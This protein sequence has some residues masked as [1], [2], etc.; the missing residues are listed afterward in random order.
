MLAVQQNTR[1]GVR[2]GLLLILTISSMMVFSGGWYMKSQP[3]TVSKLIDSSLDTTTSKDILKSNLLPSAFLPNKRGLFDEQGLENPLLRDA[4]TALSLRSRNAFVPLP[5]PTVLPKDKSRDFAR[6]KHRFTAFPEYDLEEKLVEVASGDTLITLLQR[7]ANI[8]GIEATIA[9][10]ALSKI[11]RGR[12]QPGQQFNLVMA[13]P[14]P[15]AIIQKKKLA[16]MFFRLNAESDVLLY[17]TS[18]GSYQAASIQRPLTRLVAYAAE[19][20]LRTTL[21]DAGHQVGAPHSILKKMMRIFSYTIDFQRNM[22]RGDGFAVLYE[23]FEDED[24]KVL[25]TGDILYAKL[26]LSQSDYEIFRFQPEKGKIDYFYRNGEF[27]KRSLLQ[28]PVDGVRI[29]S[30][31]GY[32]R[33]PILGYNKLHKGIDFAGPTGTPI[34]AA[35]A[36]TIRNKGWT[37]G[38]GRYIRIK[39]NNTYDT[40][41]AHMSRYHPSIK[42]GGKVRQGQIIGYIGTSGRSTGPHLHYEVLKNGVHI[43]PAQTLNL[44]SN[45]LAGADLSKFRAMVKRYD[46]RI[47]TAKGSQSNQRFHAKE[48]AIPIPI[49]AP[50]PK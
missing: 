31:F 46:K 12:L 37:G 9:S 7:N 4:A 44:G 21:Y 41:Y 14:K 22:K 39:H 13:H 48:T 40:A 24:G 3:L 28:T 10:A 26:T 16:G 19:P 6:L 45:R 11:W 32:R 17:Q 15:N 50:L 1:K 43:N 38:Y 49:P 23:R 5:P 29:S 35:G 47:A 33:H 42:Q 36:G 27:T 25:R 18:E 30:K 8:T 34:R 2:P 20:Y